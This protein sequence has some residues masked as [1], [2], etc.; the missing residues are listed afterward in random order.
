MP[1]DLSKNGA[2]RFYYDDAETEWVS[3]RL[4]TMEVFRKANAAAVKVKVKPHEER[5]DAGELVKVHPMVYE[6]KDPMAMSD[7]LWDFQ[8]ESWNLKTPGGDD[9]ACT[10]E[11]K[12]LLVYNSG[13]FLA[14]AK[15]CIGQLELEQQVLE[16]NVPTSRDG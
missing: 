4:P 6:E 7:T 12:L 14:W 1:F 13:E 16:K 10:T 15:E 2:R 5:N 8:I 3:F 11:N 9:I